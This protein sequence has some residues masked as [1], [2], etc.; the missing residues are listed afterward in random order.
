MLGDITAT[1]VHQAIAEYDAL[2]RE[3]FLRKYG[4][5]R[6][7]G[8]VLHY[9]GRTYDSKAI[10]GAAHGF[11]RPVDG[12][13]TAAE[14]SGGEATVKRKLE[15]LGFEVASPATTGPGWTEEERILALDLYLRR[16]LVGRSDRE[17]IALSQELNQ[18]AFHPD[19]GTRANFRNPNG[20]ALKLANFAALDPSYLGA[21]MSR[22]SAGDEQTW[23]E[24]AGDTD[25]LR[26][27]VGEIRSTGTAPAQPIP[28]AEVQPI[29]RAVES[30]RTRTYEV[31][32]TDDA[33]EA[34]RRE[35]DLVVRFAAWLVDR[36]ANVSA[37]HYPVV[38]PALR[39]D[40]FD[41]TA[42]RLWEAKGAVGRADV[43]MALGQLLDY[44]RFEN[45]AVQLGVLLPRRP[46]D[47]LLALVHSLGAD[48]A[49]P[50][51]EGAF[52][53]SPA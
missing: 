6:S 37:H 47:D 29:R 23:A 25:L 28:T 5:G 19:A 21:G 27:V 46:S 1:G 7:R 18:R 31:I 12:P 20:V 14:F 9:R 16:G 41:E 3:V 10:C 48:A 45:A 36:G 8:Y 26:Q 52:I 2:G 33:I 17:V 30:Q 11:D 50:D 51:G 32:P 44:R 40:L 34:E 4:F 38:R 39:N 53:V 24:Y 13:L 42:N 15:A 43:R 35:A 22:H 49:W